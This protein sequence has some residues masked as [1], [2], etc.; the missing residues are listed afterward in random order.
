[1]ENNSIILQIEENI[2]I[3]MKNGQK[4]RLSTLRM[5][6]SEM[7]LLKIEQKSELSIDQSLS[8]IQRMI[9]QRKESAVQFSNAGREELS[10]KELEEIETLKEYMPKQLNDDELK[11]EILDTIESTSSKSL[12][13]MGKVMGILKENLHGKADMSKVSNLVK[14]SLS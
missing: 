13:D 12:K 6:K 2:K 10:N 7:N 5:L 8:V 11:L 9:K 1:M 4:N 14:E 3:A